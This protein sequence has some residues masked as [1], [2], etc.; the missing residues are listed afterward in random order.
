MAQNPR[1]LFKELRDNTRLRIGL[2]LIIA[3]LAGHMLTILNDDLDKRKKEHESALQRLQ[4]L[5]TIAGQTEWPQRAKAGRALLVQFENKLWSADSKGGAKAG[6][7]TWLER[8]IKFSKISNSRLRVEPVAIAPKHPDLWQVTATLDAAF[9]RESLRAL[10]LKLGEHPQ[11]LNVDRL[12]V[13]RSGKPKLS[14]RVTAY[15]RAPAAS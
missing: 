3:I 13:R 10:L 11:L 9:A 6:F 15:F 1:S 7:R 4:R 12:E 8:Q 14:L 5:Q 2:W